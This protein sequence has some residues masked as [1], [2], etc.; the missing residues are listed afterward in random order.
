MDWLTDLF[1]P[2]EFPSFKKTVVEEDI[3]KNDPLKLAVNKQSEDLENSGL[4]TTDSMIN[5]FLGSWLTGKNSMPAQATP[6]FDSEG[7]LTGVSSKFKDSPFGTATMLSADGNFVNS[8][9]QDVTGNIVYDP[10]IG[11]FYTYD[12]KPARQRTDKLEVFP[13]SPILNDA[14]GNIQKQRTDYAA[15]SYGAQIGTGVY[16]AELAS[17]VSLLP[18]ITRGAIALPG[19]T[20]RSIETVKTKYDSIM[21]KLKDKTISKVEAKPILAALD[22]EAGNIMNQTSLNSAEKSILRTIQ[23]DKVPTYLSR[24][25]KFDDIPPLRN[26][27]T[28]AAV[29]A[30]KAKGEKTKNAVKEILDQGVMFPDEIQAALKSKGFEVGET[31]IKRYK[32]ELGYTG[33]TGIEKIVPGLVDTNLSYTDNLKNIQKT[34]DDSKLYRNRNTRE[35]LNIFDQRGRNAVQKEFIEKFQPSVKE[36]EKIIQ[37][38]KDTKGLMKLPDNFYGGLKREE[39]S[40]PGNFTRNIPNLQTAL[41]NQKTSFDDIRPVIRQN[42]LFRNAGYNIDDYLANQQAISRKFNQAK[43]DDARKQT[44]RE[45]GRGRSEGE[46][47]V[48]KFVNGRW[49]TQTSNDLE[50]S[51]ELQNNILNNSSILSD[52]GTQIKKNK[53]NYEIVSGA[54]STVQDITKKQL[55][56][57]DFKLSKDGKNL[58][59]YFEEDHIMSAKYADKGSLNDLANLQIIPRKLNTTFKK[60]ADDFIASLLKKDNISIQEKDTLKKIIT[61]ADRLGITLYVDDPVKLGVGTKKYVGYP[62]TTLETQAK[63]IIN[64]Y[65]P[66]VELPEIRKGFATGTRDGTLVGDDIVPQDSIYGQYLLNLNTSIDKRLRDQDAMDQI[67]EAPKSMQNAVATTLY[68]EEQVAFLEEVRQMPNSVRAKLKQKVIDAREVQKSL[69]ESLRDPRPVKYPLSSIPE[70]ITDNVAVKS[71]IKN[72][73]LPTIVIKSFINDLIGKEGPVNAEKIAPNAFGIF[74]MGPTESTPDESKYIDGIKEF[75]RALETGVTNIG[76]NTM[77]LILGGLDLASFSKFD[78]SEKLRDLYDEKGVN[79][80]ETFVGDMVALLTEFGAPAGL[81]TKLVT[82]A[83]KAMR[84]NGVN[85]MTRYLDPAVTGATKRG[86]QFTNLASRVGTG[87]VIFGATDF[88]AGGPYNSLK[89]MF[90]DDATLLPGK[91]E[92]TDDLNGGDLTAANFRNRLRFA[93][94]GALIGGLFPLLGPP[95]YGLVKGTAKLPFKTIPGINRSVVGGGLQLAGVPIRIAADVLAGKV[96]YTQAMI[97]AVGK[98]ISRVGEKTASA[99]QQSAAFV[100]RNVF[101]RAALAGY[102][103]KNALVNEFVAPM[104]QSG[105]TFTKGIPK[106]FGG[107]GGGLP[108][109]KQWRNFTVNNADPL[110]ANLARIDNKLAMFRDIGKLSKEAFALST[111][112]NAFIKAKSRTVEKLYKQVE[113]ISFRLA[114]TFEQQHQKWGQFSTIQKKYLDD[115]LDYVNGYKKLD[116]IDPPLRA[117]AQ[118]LKEYNRK[119]MNEFKDILPDNNKLKTLLTQ[120]ID[121]QMRKSFA[122]FTNSNFRPG[123]ENVKAARDYIAKF[124]KQDT[125]LIAEAKMA[126]PKAKNIEEAINNLAELKVGDLMHVARYEMEDPIRAFRTMVNKLEST[127]V[128]GLVD[129]LEIFTGQ[130]LPAVIRNLMGQEKNLKNSLMQTTGN[131]IASTQQKEALDR[132]AKLG[133]ENGWLFNSAEDA[134]TKGKI[135]NS[136][137]VS[138]IKGAG[139]LPSDILGLHGTPEMVQQLSGYSIFDSFLKNKIYQNFLAFK[140][141]V[142]GGKTLYSPATQMRNFGSASLFAMNVGHIGGNTS[143]TQN[144]KIMLDDIFGA[145]PKVDETALTKFIER[146][147]ELGV[148]DENVVA[149]ELGAVLRE[150]KGVRG[151]DGKPN[152]GTLNQLTQRLGDTQLTQTVQRLYAG[153]DNVWKAYGHEFYMS[154]LKQFTK[155][156][157]D[158][159][160]FFRTQ[161]GRE[162]DATVNGV[163]KTLAEGIEEMGA[164]LVRE[165]YPT[166]SRVPPAIQALRK[167]PIGNFISFPAEMI[168]TSLATT[169]SAMR[170]ISS[171]NPGLQAMGY[172]ALMG[173]FTT[174]YGFNHGAQKLASKMTGIGEDKLRAYQDDLGPEFIDDH[175]LVPIS[176]QNENGTFK[177]FDAS[178][179]NPYNYLVGPV[180]QFIR[181]L[182]STRLDPAQVDSEL[183]RRFFDATGPFMKLLDPFISE[184]IGFEPILDIYARNGVTRD[185]NRIFSELD[186]PS[187]KRE[188]AIYHAFNT[189]A[190]G[191]VRSA[192][193]VYGALTLDTKGGRVMEL[194]DV[195]IRLMGGSIM[196]VD[197]VSALEYKAIDIR[198]IR[199]AAFQTEHFFSKT[200]A[201]SRGPILDEYG[202]QKGHV[203]ANELRDIQEEAFVAQFGIWKMFHKAQAS[204]LL[205]EDQ[206][207]EVLGKKGRNVPNLKNLLDGEFTPLSFSKEALKKRADSLVNEYEAKGIDVDYDDLYPYYDLLEVID[208]FK[209]REFKDFLDPARPPLDEIKFDPEYLKSM[210]ISQAEIP[211]AP[212]DTSN[213]VDTQVAAAPKQNVIGANNQQVNNTTGLTRNEEALLSPSDQFYRRSQRGKI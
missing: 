28:S 119:I 163:P 105:A 120:D 192:G 155:S 13:T 213:F 77:D 20:V 63:D 14:L 39:L 171:G 56:N 201:L 185:G 180:E 69:A 177:V 148:L 38:L 12:F 18:M 115:V 116:S 35:T 132:I 5:N 111:K 61:E 11:K 30:T 108:E 149:N 4:N 29:K 143:V 81:V 90:P 74:N 102:D 205:T 21:Q 151:V 103:A 112:S 158:V 41:K 175:I 36:Y 208:E 174:M 146:K 203:M 24:S 196:T 22:R 94:D 195:L 172:R 93:A 49:K 82:R 133:L 135:Y 206:I 131:V 52:L 166:Y 142:Q 128:K 88:I 106:I 87:A 55:L 86:I 181:E 179:Y 122:A 76:F 117:A 130:E 176:T 194:G 40:N 68:D 182:N 23:G 170:M 71:I 198:K 80:P 178:T 7:N 189:L 212:L 121:S 97:P 34:F 123:A 156:L 153:G 37:E 191:F 165:T 47:Y 70:L 57:A 91:P 207:K 168:R 44:I 59:K 162:W 141:M 139:F 204:G 110:H 159:S 75:N 19:A 89:R 26:T 107:E 85:T 33:E 190:P 209:Y 193:Q 65:A 2:L 58:T 210:E 140:S 48:S 118:E 60:P 6:E 62:R 98:T 160:N 169:S 154:E 84:L 1:G 152:I 211:V 167:L 127:G 67:L 113:D 54:N 125:S 31:T 126:F 72:Q 186:S 200:N 46:D 129:P 183:D 99:I 95:I 43:S 32:K 3:E 51:V 92:R 101:A 25:G 199:G 104:Y 79:E 109:F 147:I 150:L 157:D 8:A 188:K 9:G 78:L 45:L 173:Q 27:D 134:L 16:Y 137:P 184:S 100:G 66:G 73:M 138:D 136:V 144:F 164:H 15:D 202:R 197:P 53:G 17:L 96:P 42:T 114:K 161:V 50:N 10:H 64:R 187:D 145:G 83:Q 124:I